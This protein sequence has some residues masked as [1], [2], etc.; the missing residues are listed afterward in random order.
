MSVKRNKGIA[1]TNE[2]SLLGFEKDVVLKDIIDL[3]LEIN[4]I[5]AWKKDLNNRYA[6]KFIE[7][8][9]S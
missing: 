5:C 2:E 1:L 9:K 7:I 6:E 8:L 3:D 4:K